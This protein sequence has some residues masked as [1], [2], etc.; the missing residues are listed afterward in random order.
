MEI[1]TQILGDGTEQAVEISVNGVMEAHRAGSTIAIH[2]STWRINPKVTRVTYDDSYEKNPVL[3]ERDFGAVAPRS[4]ESA[5][6]DK[7][8]LEEMA[9]RRESPID[10]LGAMKD[11]FKPDP[12]FEY[13]LHADLSQKRDNTAICVSHYDPNIGQVYVDFIYTIRNA[14]NWTLS[15]TRVEEYIVEL[16][17][18]GFRISTSFDGWNSAYLMER[19]TN[20]GIHAQLYSVDRGLEAYDTL[21]SAIFSGKVD[22]PYDKNFIGELSEL[23]LYGGNKY[24]HKPNGSKDTSDSVA[25]SVARCYLSIVGSL[26]SKGE[27]DDATNEEPAFTVSYQDGFPRFEGMMAPIPGVRYGVRID[28][29]GDQI[30]V[31]VGHTERAVG[32]LILDGFYLWDDYVTVDAGCES[33]VKFLVDLHSKVEIFAFSLN[34]SVPYE[35]IQFAQTSGRRFTTALA[36]KRGQRG[37]LVRSAGVSRRAVNL[38]IQQLKKGVLQIPASDP[39]IRDLKYLT[40]ANQGKRVFVQCLAGFVEFMLKQHAV[41][42]EANLLATPTQSPLSPGQS[43]GMPRLP[44]YGVNGSGGEEID[45]LRQRVNATPEN[46]GMR[47]RAVSG[48]QSRRNF[49]KP[50]G[51]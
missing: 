27:I 49:A 35:I 33:V 28:A 6:R 22:Y 19:L 48:T 7:Q 37:Q 41:G 9:T 8:A 44:S 14:K 15:F 1:Q 29:L 13:Y 4:V 43:S 10:E 40:E 24:D 38:M 16:K 50:R 17:N 11:W 26:L 23:R 36:A 21:I 30:V 12:A 47:T 25:G 3:A 2:A 45:R 31:Q 42:Q 39:L 51:M 5:V 18:R 46:M 34:E 32:N 20:A